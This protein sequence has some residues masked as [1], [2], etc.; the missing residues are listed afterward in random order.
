MTCFN[1][2]CNYNCPRN[3]FP[4]ILKVVTNYFFEQPKKLTLREISGSHE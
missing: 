2:K 3:G 1:N 4:T